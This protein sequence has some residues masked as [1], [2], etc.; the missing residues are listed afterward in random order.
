ML[1]NKNYNKVQ[2]SLFIFVFIMCV[3]KIVTSPGVLL[4]YIDGKGI[5][6]ENNEYKNLGS[7]PQVRVLIMTE[8]FKDEYH[9]ELTVNSEGI[10]VS[11]GEDF[12]NEVMLNGITLSKNH[13]YFESG[14]VRINTNETEKLTIASFERAYGCPSYYGEFEIFSH[15]E[16]LVLINELPLETYLKGVVPSEMPSSYEG[17]ALKAQS[18]CAR[19]YA[20]NQMQTISYPEYGAH[21][22]DSVAYQVYNN[23]KEAESSNQAIIATAGEKLGFNNKVVTTYFFST[24]SGHTTDV[25]AW[26]TA[27]SDQNSYL[28]G[29]E[30][31]G[32]SGDYEQELPWYRWSI[33]VNSEILRDIIELNV[34]CKIGILQGIDII[35]KGAGDVV[36]K[37]KVIGSDG[38]VIIEGE[39]SIRKALGSD[40]YNIIKNDGG[41]T[42][43]TSL[44][45]SAFFNIERFDETFIIS[46]GGLGHGIGMSQNG[47]NEMAKN[48][49][50]YL[51]ILNIFYQE[52]EI[53]L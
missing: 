46:G 50:T 47:A 19:S 36:L 38:D 32:A 11:Y 24:S 51:E 42:K 52:T 40:G 45:P 21:M 37:I 39:N 29:V 43:G 34:S 28:K 49:M 27:L 1:K 3:L 15:E 13:E 17:E 44:L 35:E 2:T 23:S 26:G 9:Q 48:N 22:N 30:V 4:E 18:V 20:Y 10:R 33:E 53:I 31:A 25:R 7:N 5:E 12:E 16:G 8:N 6:D 14:S 41:I